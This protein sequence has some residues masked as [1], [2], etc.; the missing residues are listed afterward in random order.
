MKQIILAVGLAFLVAGC[1][2][3]ALVCSPEHLESVSLA[4]VGGHFL[5]TKVEV[6]DVKKSPS[7]FGILSG[8]LVADNVKTSPRSPSEDLSDWLVAE[9]P[10]A[11]VFRPSADEASVPV[12]LS[13]AK[14]RV[15]DNNGWL[16]GINNFFSLVTLNIWPAYHSTRNDYAVTA[17]FEKSMEQMAFSVEESSLTSWLPLALCPVPVSA[18]SRVPEDFKA[19]EDQFMKT[20]ILSMF[21]KTVYD[22]NVEKR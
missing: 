11:L 12:T 18:D 21:T 2:S 1:A 5:L 15:A 13:V 22:K 19:V 14:S 3:R 10:K 17:H 6:D 16:A 7:V 4:D 9:N 8:L 20:K